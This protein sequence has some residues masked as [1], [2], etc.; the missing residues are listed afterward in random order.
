MAISIA[1]LDDYAGVAADLA[2]WDALRPHATV[3][4]FRAHLDE[5]EA[6]EQLAPFEVICTIRERMALPASLL[7][8]LPRLRLITV[9]GERLANLDLDAA[10]RLGILVCNARGTVDDRV[11]TQSATPELAWALL[12]AL[13]RQIPRHDRE[14]RSG[15][16]QL[17]MGT[18]LHGK[19]M[20]ILGL[21]HLGRRV[22][23]YAR[24]FGMEVIAWSE[25]LTDEAARAAG[26][27]RV[28][29]DAFF[30]RS[31]AISIH[32]RFSARTRGLVGVRELGLMKPGAFLIN[33]SRGPIVDEPALIDALAARRI[34]GA[35]LDVFDREP[36]PAGHPLRDLPNVVVTP[37]LGYFT[38]ELMSLFYRGTQATVAA[39]LDGRPAAALNAPPVQAS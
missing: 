35:G 31:D 29:R 1:V 33:T 17:G 23:G 26:A 15:G 12:L 2:D 27:V 10:T 8:R 4:F 7:A 37:H 16:W 14:M 18:I 3:R 11:Q 9:I 39:W 30:A 6:A 24:A 21:G 36:L 34:G 20:G 32:L 28:E 19:T 38:Q 22:A 5:E 13:A 25:N